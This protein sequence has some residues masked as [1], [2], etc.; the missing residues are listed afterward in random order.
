MKKISVIAMA[1]V[2]TIA[3]AQHD[4]KQTP[5]TGSKSTEDSK[6]K[7]SQSST[8]SNDEGR[9]EGTYKITLT[10]KTGS[11]DKSQTGMNSTLDKNTMSGQNSNSNS[12]GTNSQNY[13][14]N[15]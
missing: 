6:T 12:Y 3:F 4:Q 13:G 5:S 9:A 2:S 11:R 7:T 10:A 15:N 1:L 14:S 8:Y